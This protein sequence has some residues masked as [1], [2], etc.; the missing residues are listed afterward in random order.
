M[1]DSGPEKE[2]CSHTLG[3]HS[4]DRLPFFYCRGLGVLLEL[5]FFRS[6]TVSLGP[7]FSCDLF[8]EVIWILL[9]SS[10]MWAV[11]C[12]HCWYVRRRLLMPQ[13]NLRR[14]RRQYS[15]TRRN[16]IKMH[17][18]LTSVEMIQ[19]DQIGVDGF[20]PYLLVRRKQSFVT[21]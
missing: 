13:N 21:R 17:R 1:R 10:M 20:L 8:L 15:R 11:V 4:V 3:S 18:R 14:L 6:F 2:L 9:A 19:A 7:S 16:C 5:S 12:V